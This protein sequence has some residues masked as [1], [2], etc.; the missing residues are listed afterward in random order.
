MSRRL[1]AVATVAAAVALTGL[2]GCSERPQIR[3]AS[4]KTPD[5]APWAK[6]DSALPAFNAPGWNGGDQ[7]AWDK[8]IHDRTQGQND[9]SPR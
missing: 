7:A 9:Y 8:Q 2:A 3:D 4:T 6:S 5:A 1:I